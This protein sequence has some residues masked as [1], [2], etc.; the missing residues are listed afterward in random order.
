M[1]RAPL[2]GQAPDRGAGGRRGEERPGPERARVN[3]PQLEEV[4]DITVGA[5]HPP[6]TVRRR[7]ARA[8]VG[9]RRR[10]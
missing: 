7:D 3:S 10:P 2:H 6:R 5:R 4:P 1:T 9:N 8:E